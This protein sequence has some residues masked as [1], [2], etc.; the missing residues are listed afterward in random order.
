MGSDWGTD[1]PFTNN[2]PDLVKNGDLDESFVDKALFNTLRLRFLLGLFDPISNQ[3]YWSVS[4]SIIN[5]E[6][7]RELNKFSARQSMTLLKNDK[8]TLPF[9]T[10]FQSG[11]FNVAVIGPHY[12]V[13][14]VLLGSYLGEICYDG[15]DDCVP[16][17]L[18]E[19]Q[20][21]FDEKGANDISITYAEGCDVD[22][23]STNGFSNAYSV[24]QAADLVILMM[25]I[26]TQVERESEFFLCRPFALFFSHLS[27]RP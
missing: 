17:F 1:G 27:H 3:P 18:P 24:A 23:T 10:D 11:K 5:N 12:N 2:I 6:Y 21:F 7:A 20:K 19:L 9:S 15:S 8:K 16:A 4:G 25:G 14:S 26:N 13:S 22:C